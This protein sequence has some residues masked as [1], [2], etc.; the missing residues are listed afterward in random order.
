MKATGDSS[1]EYWDHLWSDRKPALYG[2]PAV[3]SHPLL[4]HFLPKEPSF[5]FLEIGCV[6]GNWMVYFHKEYGY[7]VSGIDYSEAISVAHKTC[8]INKVPAVIW[9]EDVL[10]A[11]LP[12]LF[13][14]IFSA[15]FL[16]HFHRW[17]QVVDLHLHWLKPGGYLVIS[18]P[19]IR[20]IH[21]VFFKAYHPA[22]YAMHYLDIIQ[23]PDKLRKHLEQSCRLLYFGYWI[24][25]R[26]F[27]QLPK[28][29]DFSS[30]AVR[31]L[32]RLTG[33]QNVPNRYFS[34]FLWVIARK[35]CS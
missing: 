6:P 32:L 24:T 5:K 18:V 19:N 33:L 13:D 4:K 27:Y 7:Q 10:S 30:R 25:W 14:V 16:E 17:K 31:K 29:F 11:K 9:Q 3:E 21:R 2:G 20:A 22:D 26:P 35:H 1:K 23:K 28:P 8:E 12:N 15:G 34:P